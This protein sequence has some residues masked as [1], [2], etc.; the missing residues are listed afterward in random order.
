MIRLGHATRWTLVVVGLLGSSL[1]WCATA[2][3]LSS[4][5][6]S[7]A[8]EPNYEWKA[9]HFDAVAAERARSAALG[10]TLSVEVAREAPGRSSVRL[11]VRDA[12]GQP[13]EG[14]T[15][16]VEAFHN[17]RAADRFAL[18]LTPAGAGEFSAPLASDRRGTWEFDAVVRAHGAVARLSTRA[19][20][21]AGG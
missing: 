2:I 5:D 21:T 4:G 6:P 14:A 9:E 8:V 12:A 13:L 1:A 17:A 10:W 19:L 20:L 11:G 18:A 15:V 16:E 3:F 7:F